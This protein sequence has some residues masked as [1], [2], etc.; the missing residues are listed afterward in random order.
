MSDTDE[1]SDLGNDDLP[2]F[3]PRAQLVTPS[4]QLSIP[5]RKG[6]TVL[7]AMTDEEFAAFASEAP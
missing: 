2:I 6:L 1:F 3:P 4:Q 5:V 7:A